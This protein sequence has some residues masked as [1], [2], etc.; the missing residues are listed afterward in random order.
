MKILFISAVLP[1]PLHSGGQIRMYQLLKRLSKRHDITLVSFIRDQKERE[2]EKNLGFCKE[3]HMIHRGYAW[4]FG[5]LF[6]ALTSSYPLLLATY[7]NR[8][9]YALLTR[10]LSKQS[11]DVVHMEPFYV[12]PSVPNGRIP[13]VISEH[14]VEYA[15]YKRYVSGYRIPLF[16]PVMAW[17]VRKLLSWERKIWRRATM[18]TAVSG[19]DAHVIEEYLSHD[20]DVIPNGVDLDMFT[21]QKPGA[22]SH[23][24]ALFVGNFRWLPNR[25]A[26][27]ELVR[28][29][30]PR[31]KRSHPDATLTVVGRYIPSELAKK[32]KA[33]GGTIQENVSDITHVYHESDVLIAPHAI[34]GGTKYKMLEAM[35]SGL[36]VVT[37]CHGMA[38]LEA[39][40]DEH[41]LEAHTPEEFETAVARIW[42]D[43]ALRERLAKNAH[44]LVESTYNWDSIATRL[45]R[46]W[47]RAYEHKKHLA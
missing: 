25:E 41:Y 19:A 29:I 40:P 20:I 10:L 12:W 17:D 1:Y 13:T 45:D 46:V 23:K 24:R 38:G 2:F 16:R 37:T 32:I 31:I 18:V 44:T 28:S 8:H 6:N 4:Q 35:A 3:V 9:M 30:W 21:F 22:M 26:A 34:A 14:N 42:T 43:A 47:K 5:Y 33:A 7:A 39:E 11:F 15:V 27:Y 36:P